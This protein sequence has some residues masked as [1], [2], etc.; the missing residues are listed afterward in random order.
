MWKV[1]VLDTCG[2]VQLCFQF[3]VCDNIN[4]K[5]F[6][7]DGPTRNRING[8]STGERVT[9]E[10]IFHLAPFYGWPRLNRY[11]GALKRAKTA[12]PLDYHYTDTTIIIT[13]TTTTSTTNNAATGRETC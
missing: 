1:I 3:H 4:K 5:K 10:V 6:Y 11:F 12:L 7:G 8:G 2:C 9:V 13:T